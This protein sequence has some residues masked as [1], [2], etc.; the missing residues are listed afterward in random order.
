MLGKLGQLGNILP[1]QLGEEAVL[2]WLNQER[3]ALLVWK[4]QDT[5]CG[6]QNSIEVKNVIGARNANMMALATVLK[7]QCM[8]KLLNEN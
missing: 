6:C 7:F 3:H 2:L 8:S 4:C 1:S 5:I